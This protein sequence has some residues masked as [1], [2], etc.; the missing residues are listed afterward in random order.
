MNIS[1]NRTLKIAKIC[2]GYAIFDL[3][4]P[5]IS[6]KIFLYHFKNLA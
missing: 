5:D 4:L 3:Q 6:L 1:A 2:L